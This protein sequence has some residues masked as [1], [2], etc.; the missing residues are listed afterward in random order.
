MDIDQAGTGAIIDQQQFF[1]EPR[2]HQRLTGR[3]ATVF[4][5]K[6]YKVSIRKNIIRKRKKDKI[7][8]KEYT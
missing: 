1:V 3:P 5:I 8:K 2:S 6:F 4:K 7:F